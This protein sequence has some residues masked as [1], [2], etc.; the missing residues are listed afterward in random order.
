MPVFASLALAVVLAAAPAAA[1]AA[2]VTSA[3]PAPAAT[4]LARARAAQG[5]DAWDRLATMKVTGTFATGGLEGPA[6]SLVDLETGRFKDT[7]ALGP[8][9]GAAGFDGQDGWSQDESGMARVDGGE[10]ARRGT[11][12]D[13]YRRAQAWWYPVRRPGELR[14]REAVVEAGR[15]LEVV[16]VLPAGGRPFELWIDAATGLFDRTVERDTGRTFVTTFSDW[17]EVGGVKV[18][19][20]SRTRRDGDA[21]YDQLTR[22]AKVEWN[23]PVQAADF[24]LPAPPPADSGFAG[25]ARATTVPLEIVNG[26]LYVDVKLDGKGPYKLLLDTGG[27]NIVT[28][29]VARAL[30]LALEGHLPGGGVGE[31]TEDI[32]ASRVKRVEIGDA[33]VE[34]QVFYVFGLDAMDPVEGLPVQGVVGYEVLRRFVAR[35]DYEGSRLALLDP[36]TFTYEGPGTAVPFV[37]EDHVPQVE[38]AVD[39][40][41]AR[42]D[43]DTGSRA[44]LDL[45]GPFVREHGLAAR[46]GVGPER[47][48]GWGVG[49][50]SRGKPARVGSLRLGAVEVP[51]VWAGLSTAT[52]GAFAREGVA[53]NVGAGVLS[54]FTVT[55][56]YARQRVILEPNGRFPVPVEP[57]RSGL[58]LHLAA[59]GRAFE[60]KEVVPGSAA[61]RAGLAPGDRI[62][63]VDGRSPPGLSLHA[64]RVALR[65]APGTPVRLRVKPLHR[66]LPRPARLVLADP[67]P[68]K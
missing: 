27:V 32:Q 23:V 35:I 63:E 62:L 45:F 52:R 59:D 36:A 2:P 7:F 3:A 6:T 60:V 26:H 30:G 22:I 58:W 19:F 66:G 64:V 16:E 9:S 65:A 55:L 67:V 47:I 39:G 11:L 8:I 48:L 50:P 12:A 17:R 41:P 57:D 37:F 46:P 40:I 61:A 54:R 43:L 42:L 18:P 53:G 29:A 15:R 38:G 34:R 20:E 28:P 14:S 10:A 24:A 44:S 49:G 13:A 4:L 31:Q 5:G 33:F 25:A 68:P 21:K 1:P 51:V 56:D